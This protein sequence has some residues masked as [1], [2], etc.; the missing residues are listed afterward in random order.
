[1]E[2]QQ[3]KSL[4][5]NMGFCSTF[6]LKIKQPIVLF[7][8]RT[9]I[10]RNLHKILIFQMLTKRPC[11]LFHVKQTFSL[12][13]RY[14]SSNSISCLRKATHEIILVGDRSNIQFPMPFRYLKDGVAKAS[15]IVL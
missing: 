13:N 3:F 12:I 8:N 15:G 5:F 9:K 1:M 14:T 10:R 11:R 2:R 7:N 4:G 6:F